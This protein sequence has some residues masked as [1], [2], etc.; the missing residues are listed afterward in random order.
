MIRKSVMVFEK[1]GPHNTETC[2]EVVREAVKQGIVHVVV[3]STSGKTGLIMA[4]ALNGLGA[5]L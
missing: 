5:N 4:S 1:P 2:I 3:A